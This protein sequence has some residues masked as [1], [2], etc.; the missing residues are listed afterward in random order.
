M[1]EHGTKCQVV[2]ASLLVFA[3]AVGACRRETTPDA[4]QARL[5]AAESMQLKEQLADLE[6]QIDRLKAEHAHQ[7]GQRDKQLAA[8]RQRIE[9]L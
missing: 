5:I 6:H 1:A 2:I 8:S 3:L 4:R 9:T 7:I